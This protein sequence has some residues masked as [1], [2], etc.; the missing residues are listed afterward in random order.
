MAKVCFE[1]LHGLYRDYF[2]QRLK[3]FDVKSVLL[4]V[5]DRLA[6]PVLF[7][8]VSYFFVYFE[9]SLNILERLRSVLCLQVLVQ[10]LV[11]SDLHDQVYSSSEQ[12]I[13][14]FFTLLTKLNCDKRN[15]TTK[16]HRV[17]RSKEVQNDR[18]VKSTLL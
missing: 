2:N 1:I 17:S 12:F 13:L 9:R 3:Y 15:E 4:L 8:L 7:V 11:R 14:R 6:A 5:Y 16:H 10:R 18:R